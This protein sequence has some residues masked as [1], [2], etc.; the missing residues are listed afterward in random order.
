MDGSYPTQTLGD[1]DL[2]HRPG[3]A[4]KPPYPTSQPGPDPGQHDLL[5]RP[6]QN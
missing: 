4:R 3:P 2:P 5:Y 1:V 6:I